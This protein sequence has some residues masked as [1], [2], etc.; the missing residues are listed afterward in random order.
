M[1]SWVAA[2]DQAHP[3][4]KYFGVKWE[5]LLPESE[6]LRHAGPDSPPWENIG[7]V[8][9]DTNAFP[10]VITGGANGPGRDFYNALDYSPFTNDILVNFTEQAMVNE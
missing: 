6:Y 4:D 1:P 10:H 5:R 3:A 8:K 2:F 9:D 7:D